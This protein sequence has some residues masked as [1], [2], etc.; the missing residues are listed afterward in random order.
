[1][2]INTNIISDIFEKTKEMANFWINYG[3]EHTENPQTSHIL[4]YLSLTAGYLK[5]K[6]EAEVFQ[7]KWNEIKNKLKEGSDEQDWMNQSNMIQ[8]HLEQALKEESVHNP[9]DTKNQGIANFYKN[10]FP[11]LYKNAKTEY[12]NFQ[13]KQKDMVKAMQEH[14]KEIFSSQESWEEALRN[15]DPAALC[16]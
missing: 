4:Y 12:E 6:E 15:G 11:E 5:G 8:S 10:K 16:D 1:M 7:Y 9:E 2:S 13:K 3:A 14:H